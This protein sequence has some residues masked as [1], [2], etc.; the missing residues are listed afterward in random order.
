MKQNIFLSFGLDLIILTLFGN[1]INGIQSP[2]D[3]P[4]IGGHTGAPGET[5]CNGCHP[6]T[7]NSGNA[8]I[9]F[10]L[11]TNTY[12]PGQ[13]Y[14]GFVRLQQSGMQQFGFS[15]LALRKSNNTTTGTFGLTDPVRTRTYMDGV[16]RYVSHTPCSADS[17]NANSWY[18]TWKAPATNVDTIIMYLGALA[19]NHNHTTTGDFSY[20][21]IIKLAPQTLSA[22]KPVNSQSIQIYPNPIYNTF[23]VNG[24]NENNIRSLSIT[25]TDGKIIRA[26]LLWQKT[27][28]NAIS[29]S[30]FA[31]LAPGL[32]LFRLE[33]DKTVLTKKI[34]VQ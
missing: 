8:T 7:A 2:C 16:R 12:V 21:R 14:T 9:D 15:C 13:T 26:Q 18:F 3:S 19:G 29:V 31:P 6:G 22:L 5:G 32:Y 34:M 11:G 27:S 17:L 4:L 23:I 28:S 30:G 25:T 10:D 20:Q 24:L 1:G 33:T